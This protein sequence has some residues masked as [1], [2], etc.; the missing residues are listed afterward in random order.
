MAKMNLLQAVNSAL[1]IAMAKSDKVYSFGED[2]GAFGGVFRA[3]S[4]LTEKYGR[5]RNFNTPLVEQGIIG[6]ANGL[7]SQ[8]SYAR[9][10]ERRVGKECRSRWSQVHG[11]K[12]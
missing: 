2:T 7:A 1:D 5:H 11:R 8:G 9:S 4:G 10:E 12:K 3:T 6:F